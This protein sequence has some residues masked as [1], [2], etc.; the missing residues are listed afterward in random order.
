[1]CCRLSDHKF[2]LKPGEA[3]KLVLRLLNG[4]PSSWYSYELIDARYVYTVICVCLHDCS[5]DPTAYFQFLV[6][7][8]ANLNAEYVNQNR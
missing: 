8:G 2:I 4:P 6:D 7:H 5:I 3:D 1:M